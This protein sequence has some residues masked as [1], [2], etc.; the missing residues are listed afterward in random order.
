MDCPQGKRYARSPRVSQG[1]GHPVLDQDHLERRGV[2][3]WCARA[4]ARSPFTTPLPACPRLLFMPTTGEGDGRMGTPRSGPGSRPTSTTGPS[5]VLA[6]RQLAHPLTRV[7]L[8]LAVSGLMIDQ[9]DTT[10]SAARRVDGEGG[11][12]QD[13]GAAAGQRSHC[14]LKAMA[15]RWLQR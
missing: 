11:H 14:R 4:L 13:E 3:D 8:G 12:S 6:F 5:R 7:S 9:G 15:L 2:G 1:T 10:P